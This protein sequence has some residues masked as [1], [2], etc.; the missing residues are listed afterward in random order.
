MDPKS[1]IRN[2]EYVLREESGTQTPVIYVHE[3]INHYVFISNKQMVRLD[4]YKV[5]TQIYAG[6]V[7]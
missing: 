3:T 4:P 5:N 1:L 7:E 6:K 2:N